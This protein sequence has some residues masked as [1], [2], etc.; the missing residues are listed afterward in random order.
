MYEV[1]YNELPKYNDK[2][3]GTISVSTLRNLQ[4]SRNSSPVLGSALADTGI[5]ASLSAG[6][7]HVY[8]SATAQAGFSNGAPSLPAAAHVRSSLLT[9]FLDRY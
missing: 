8:S 6:N 1:L 4:R 5:L 9:N 3:R 2:R 7:G